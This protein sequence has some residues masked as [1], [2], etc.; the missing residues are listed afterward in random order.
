MLLLWL[1]VV[2]VMGSGEDG[3]DTDCD[4]LDTLLVFVTGVVCF[5]VDVVRGI[6][7]LSTVCL[8]VLGLVLD[9]L[10]LLFRARSL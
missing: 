5:A 10:V 9:P 6:Q 3:D 1:T 4:E 2:D 8:L 7:T